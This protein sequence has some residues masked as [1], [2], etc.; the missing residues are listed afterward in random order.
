[1]FARLILLTLAILAAGTAS[2]SRQT[3]ELISCGANPV[4]Y[5]CFGVDSAAP[6]VKVRRIQELYADGWRLV[7]VQVHNNSVTYWLERPV[8]PEQ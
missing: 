3:H 2:A 7:Q 8:A 1:M 6:V 5:E 4:F